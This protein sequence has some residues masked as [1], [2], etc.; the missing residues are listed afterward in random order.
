MEGKDI[1]VSKVQAL[2]SAADRC[3]IAIISRNLEAFAS[4]YRDSFN[5]QVAMFPAMIQGSVQSFIDKY[6]ALP[7][8]Q[9][10]KMPG[11]GGGGFLACVVTDASAFVTEHPEAIRLTIRRA[12]M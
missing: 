9:A 10:W 5:A 4:A 8:V 3:W 6:S 1:T 7:D 11:A 12:G 2:A